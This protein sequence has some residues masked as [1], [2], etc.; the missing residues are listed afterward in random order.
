M[1]LAQLQPHPTSWRCQLLQSQPRLRFTTIMKLHSEL[2]LQ[3]S[4]GRRLP[5]KL[6]QKQQDMWKG[7]QGK[8]SHPQVS[9]T[10]S[11][12]RTLD[13][14]LPQMAQAPQQEVC[15]TLQES[16]S[17]QKQASR[18]AEGRQVMLRLTCPATTKSSL[19]MQTLRNP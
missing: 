19:C 8:G 17:C 10:L 12:Q 6:Q 3:N 11:R 1:L 2:R 9:H 14:S 13:Q 18:L 16:R 15:Q 4:S 5:R 7:V